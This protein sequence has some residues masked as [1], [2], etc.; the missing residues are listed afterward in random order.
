[1]DLNTSLPPRQHHAQG[2]LYFVNPNWLVV[3][4]SIR[5]NA[6]CQV[7]LQLVVLGGPLCSMYVAVQFNYVPIEINE[8]HCFKYFSSTHT[9]QILL[10]LN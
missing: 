2:H 1:M 7:Y 8:H 10:D 9:T 5:C 4:S 3:A 6:S